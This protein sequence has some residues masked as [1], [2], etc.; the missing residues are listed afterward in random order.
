M[1]AG[2]TI[3]YNVV[4]GGAASGP[5]QVTMPS[6]ALTSPAQF[7]SGTATY[8]GGSAGAECVVR[9]KGYPVRH[10]SD[11]HINFHLNRELFVGQQAHGLGRWI[12]PGHHEH[13]PGPEQRF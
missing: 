13:P 5:Y 4:S 8:D 7:L 9:M 11:L 12:R 6:T 10:E 2:S 3:H 1:S